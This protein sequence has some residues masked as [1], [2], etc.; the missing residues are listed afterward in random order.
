MD[1]DHK[2][3]AK[4][5]QFSV[6]TGCMNRNANLV[7]ALP[8]WL[9]HDE[10][11][12]V[13]I[14]D[15]SSKTKVADSVA[16]V[17]DERV[18]LIRVDGEAHWVNTLAF[19]LAAKY[20]SKQYLLRIDSDVLL[21]PDF[22]QVHRFNYAEYMTGNPE[23]DKGLTGMLY[24]HRDHFFAVNGYNEFLRSYGWEDIDMFS[25]LEI[26]QSLRHNFFSPGTAEH[27]PHSDEE[28]TR[29][30]HLQGYLSY[31]PEDLLYDVLSA[32][33]KITSRRVGLTR[34]AR[35]RRLEELCNNGMALEE[36][37]KFVTAMPMF[38]NMKNRYLSEILPW[39]SSHWQAQY[40]QQSPDNTK[41]LLLKRAD[42]NN[43]VPDDIMRKAELYSFIKLFSWTHQNLISPLKEFG[44]HTAPQ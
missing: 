41:V 9:T 2:N 36:S 20:T 35:F 12:E 14:I 16:D 17:R 8:T 15:W 7:S 23:E 31:R 38:H 34:D 3:S 37:I 44:L 24:V 28:R 39:S 21:K 43:L 40:E 1:V 26:G 5:G 6:F 10:I 29:H 11:G 13:V 32:L 25:R 4:P 19:N 22:F 33:E 18:K 27:I 30:P 42:N